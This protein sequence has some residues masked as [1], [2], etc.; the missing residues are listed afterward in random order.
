MYRINV[1]LKQK[2]KL[3]HTRD[4]ALLWGNPVPNTLYTTI[5][6]YVQRGILIPIHKGFYSVMPISKIDPAILGISY[7]H[8]YAYLSLE[9]ILIEGGVIFQ[10]GEYITLVSNVSKKFT[11]GS[12][13]Y[14]VRKMKDGF[15]YNTAGIIDHHVRRATLERAVADM[16]YFNP[17]F[18]FDNPKAIDW[19]RVKEIQ[20]EVGYR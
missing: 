16:F 9:S 15:L 14:L 12:Y 3:F 4:L 7:L 11:V 5:K 17:K 13:T 1:L 20:K 2:R 10:K 6:R 19:M 18:Y 8:T